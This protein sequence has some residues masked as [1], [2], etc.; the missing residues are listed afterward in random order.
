MMGELVAHNILK[1]ENPLDYDPG[2]WFN[3]AKFFNIEYQ[4]YGE[5]PSQLPE[6]IQTLFWQSED[7]K[8]SVRI[9]FDKE[10]LHVRGFNLM[11]VRFRQQVCE[12]WIAEQT[13]IDQVLS[14]LEL[15]AFDPEF[16][17]HYEEALRD[18]FKALTGQSVKKR[19]S[20]KLN[21]VLQFL[22]S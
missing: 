10:K 9:N 4:V 1:P 5:V 18:K 17:R 20:R 2:I 21:R 11:G 13:R 3:S 6:D 15:A 22:N 19:S 14:N 8:K 12:K 16:F 7:G